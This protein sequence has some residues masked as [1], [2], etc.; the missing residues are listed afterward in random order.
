MADKKITALTENTAL[1]STDLFHIV[2]DPT[3]SPSNQK[4]TVAN[5]MNKIPSYIGHSDTPQ[6]LT[7][8]GEANATT[9]VTTVSHTGGS[10]IT[11]TMADGVVSGQI[12]HIVSLNTGD[13][14]IDDDVM[15]STSVLLTVAGQGATFMWLSSKWACI[16]TSGAAAT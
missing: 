13:V 6:A 5:V 2:D 10:P 14:T 1:A 11:V 16:G 12:K 3:S 15:W 9:S 4:I 7:A 8:A